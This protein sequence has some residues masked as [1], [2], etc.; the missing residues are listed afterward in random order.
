MAPLKQTESDPSIFP[1][2]L[3]DC[4]NAVKPFSNLPLCTDTM[5]IEMS[6]IEI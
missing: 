6:V 4:L 5:K 1:R 3:Q 2:M